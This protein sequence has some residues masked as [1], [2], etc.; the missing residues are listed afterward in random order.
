[1]IE[2]ECMG[3]ERIVI[4]KAWNDYVQPKRQRPTGQQLQLIKTT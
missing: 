4:T 2:K 1:M 3:Q